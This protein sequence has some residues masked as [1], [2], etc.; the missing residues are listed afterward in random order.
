MS[1]LTKKGRAGH[2]T[3]PENLLAVADGVHGEPFLNPTAASS[4]AASAATSQRVCRPIYLLR[5]Q[6]QPGVDEVRALRWALKK[7]LRLGLRC[8]SVEAQR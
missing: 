8:V 2:A 1:A 7:L 3:L 6:A 4:Q 5:L